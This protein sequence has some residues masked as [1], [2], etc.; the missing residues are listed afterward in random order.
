[1]TVHASIRFPSPYRRA[2]REGLYRDNVIKIVSI[3]TVMIYMFSAD[4]NSYAFSVPLGAFIIPKRLTNYKKIFIMLSISTI[5]FLSSYAVSYTNNLML[6]AANS[7]LIRI[8]AIFSAYLTIYI[9]LK[10][11]EYCIWKRFYI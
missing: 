11:S 7:L 6:R 4:I 8:G 10:I 3:A 1:M 9:S 5:S 2:E